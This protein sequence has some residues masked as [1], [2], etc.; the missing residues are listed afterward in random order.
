MV[1]ML[2]PPRRVPNRF[3]RTLKFCQHTPLDALCSHAWRVL[4]Q[5]SPQH[6][7][8]DGPPAAVTTQWDSDTET[9]DSRR[10]IVDALEFD[11]TR[12]DSDEELV[13]L[14]SPGSE[15]EFEESVAGEEEAAPVSEEAFPDVPDVRAAVLRAAF[16][17]LNDVDPCH[18]FR[19]R[20]AVMKSVPK[21][22]QGLFRNA[23]KVALKEIIEGAGEV[24][25]E[26]G[27]KLLLML[28]RMLLHR[29]PGGSKVSKSKLRARF[30]SCSR[31]DRINL[32]VASSA[33]RERPFHAA[34]RTDGHMTTSRV[35]QP[36]LRCWCR[37]GNS[38]Q[39]G[40][41]LRELRWLPESRPL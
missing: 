25:Q 40:E 27:W 3:Q 6:T 10:S 39:L 26:R 20:A 41:Q 22:L 29:P 15:V 8:H 30:E 37:W 11:L 13:P 17:T 14:D 35:V 5:K 16:R 12:G 24:E 31:G 38:H 34:G 33:M 36:L 1:L 19:Q 32:I 21:F 2:V 23:L 4:Q 18:Q 7:L 28:P 9:Q